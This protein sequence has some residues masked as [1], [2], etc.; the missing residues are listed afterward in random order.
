MQQ[1]LAEN[2]GHTIERGRVMPTLGNV[3]VFRS[4]YL[5]DGVMYADAVRVPPFG[6]TSARHGA[7]LPVLAESDLP[8]PV[9]QRVGEVVAGLDAFACGFVAVDPKDR[10]GDRVYL[11]DMR[12]SIA[13]S[14]FKPLWGVSVSTTGDPAPQWAAFGRREADPDE[15]LGELLDDLFDRAGMFRPLAELE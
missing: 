5:A 14:G 7:S 10:G 3:V 8:Q 9:G 2:R 11:G 4:L 1:A 6:S 12:I 15:L 13:T